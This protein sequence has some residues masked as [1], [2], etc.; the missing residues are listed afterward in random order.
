MGGLLCLSGGAFAE[1]GGILRFGFPL[2][3]FFTYFQR[4]AQGLFLFGSKRVA[5]LYAQRVGHLFA[6]LVGGFFCGK[7]FALLLHQLPL[8]QFF[9]IEQAVR[10]AETLFPYRVVDGVDTLAHL[11]YLFI[12]RL[13]GE[14]AQLYTAVD[15]FFVLAARRHE[16]VDESYAQIR[17][18]G[19]RYDVPALAFLRYARVAAALRIMGVNIVRG[20]KQSGGTA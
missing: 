20:I 4:L 12:E 14:V 13:T 15:R 10:T 5:Q 17:Y 6:Q 1:L 8:F 2:Q 16:P 11:I 9:L 7:F 18:Q 3:L 19:E